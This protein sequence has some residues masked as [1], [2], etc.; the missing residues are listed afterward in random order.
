MRSIYLVSGCV[1]LVMA[2]SMVAPERTG[3]RDW[4]LALVMV[5]AAAFLL[6]YATR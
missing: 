1:G 4:W 6:R 2:I 3:S 5:N